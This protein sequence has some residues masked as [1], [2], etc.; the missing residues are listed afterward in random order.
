M[1]KPLVRQFGFISRTRSSGWPLLQ[2]FFLLGDFLILEGAANPES[3]KDSVRYRPLRAR[4]HKSSL[5]SGACSMSAYFCDPQSP[6][7]HGSNENTNGLLRQ[8]FP[9][10]WTQAYPVNA[11]STQERLSASVKARCEPHPISTTRATISNVSLTHCHEMCGIK[12]ET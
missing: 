11:L 7:Q 10:G 4:T 5:L 2:V 3:A 8:Y 6:W 12:V 9:K 1:R